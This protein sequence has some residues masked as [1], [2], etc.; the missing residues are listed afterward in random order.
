MGIVH[1]CSSISFGSTEE[2][3]HVQSGGVYDSPLGPMLLLAHRQGLCGL[4]F[5]GQK[6]F[7]PY[8][9]AEVLTHFLKQQAAESS[10]SILQ[11]TVAW[12]QAYFASWPQDQYLTASQLQLMEQQLHLKADDPTLCHEQRLRLHQLPALPARPAVQLPCLPPLYILGAP[13]QQQIYSAL[14]AVPYG[15]VRAYKDIASAVNCKMAAISKD[16][17]PHHSA[18]VRLV[19]HYIG[20]NPL[21]IV[22]PCHRVLSVSGALSGY[23]AGLERKKRLLQAE[24]ASSA[25]YYT[26]KNRE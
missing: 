13:L 15:Q 3:C 7:A 8:V 25:T 22:V 21:S 6:N 23:N 17:L 2:Y 19:A 5:I 12:L 18:R 14:L 20:K 9:K 11:G 4:Y 16:A 1:Q 24:R 10:N 26:G